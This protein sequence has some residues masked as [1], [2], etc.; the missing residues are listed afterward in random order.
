LSKAFSQN[1]ISLDSFEDGIHRYY[2]LDLSR[3]NND[4]LSGKSL[5]LCGINNNL[6]DIDLFNYVI[7]N[8]I[9]I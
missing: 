9:G 4:D 6:V 3:R 1:L 5:R 7:Y 2:Y 8:K